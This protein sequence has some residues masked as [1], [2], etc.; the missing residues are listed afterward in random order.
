MS[1]QGNPVKPGV[2]DN[3]ESTGVAFFLYLLASPAVFVLV[4][5][6]L[7]PWC[8][9]IWNSGE[10]LQCSAEGVSQLVPPAITLMVIVFQTM[11]FHRLKVSE[12]LH[13]WAVCLGTWL[14]VYFLGFAAASILMPSLSFVAGSEIT[15]NGMKLIWYSS[16]LAVVVATVRYPF[17]IASRPARMAAEQARERERVKLAAKVEKA[18]QQKLEQRLER[19]KRHK[20][21]REATRWGLMGRFKTIGAVDDE[22]GLIVPETTFECPRCFGLTTVSEAI[23]AIYGVEKALKPA[24]K[25][26]LLAVRAIPTRYKPTDYTKYGV[27]RGDAKPVYAPSVLQEVNG[28][29]A[30]EAKAYIA[31]TE[32]LKLFAPDTPLCEDCV[33]GRSRATGRRPMSPK[34]RLAVLRHDGYTCQECGANKSSDPDVVLQIDHIQPV[35]AGG[36]DEMENLQVLCQDCNLGKSDDT[37]YI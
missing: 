30:S 12:F 21:T 4:H 23:A 7:M 15:E 5:L 34:L 17:Q 20:P 33:K 8:Q 27:L 24:H 22:S 35:A 2:P 18:E 19:Q 37:T 10:F 3:S 1:P 32:K 28:F 6:L 9:P 36:Q 16:I 14:L 13:W 11:L 25:E 31:A 29:S 26:W